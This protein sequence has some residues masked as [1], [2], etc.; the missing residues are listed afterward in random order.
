MLIPLDGNWSIATDP[1][2]L[3]R[4]QQW[5]SGPLADAKTTRVPGII[6]EA[7]PGYHGVAWYWR[8]FA[9]PANPHP[10]GRTRLRFW[11]VDYQAEVWVNG[12]TVGGHEGGETPF[13]LDVTAAVR[14]GEINLLAV[15]VLNPTNEPLDG[16]VLRETPHRNKTVPPRNGGGYNY[17]G[18][19]EPVELL[20]VPA[21]RV[22]ELFVRANPKTGAI[23]TQVHVHNTGSHTVRGRLRVSVTPELT[24]APLRIENLEA[25]LPSGLT[26]IEV[27]LS[28]EN[29]RLWDLHDPFLYRVTAQLQSEGPPSLDECSARCGFRDFRVLPPERAP[30]LR[31]QHAHRQPLP[32]GAGRSPSL[33]AGSPPARP[34]LRQGFG[35]QYGPLYRRR[36]SSLAAR[37]L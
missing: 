7:F 29:P 5:W 2:N 6:Q 25:S 15:R 35:L 26:Q 4:E 28:L 24:G 9:A 17:G 11:A 37:L 27:V 33:R 12:L 34:D 18:I 21:V 13:V 20:L 19:I 22:E 14:P 8:E 1:Q 16:I 10:E 30:D 23:H 31:A 3:G 32:G 36:G